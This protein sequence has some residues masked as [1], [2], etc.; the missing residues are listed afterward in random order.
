MVA[1]GKNQQERRASF[2]VH[3]PQ[4]GKVA[5]VVMEEEDDEQLSPATTAESKTQSKTTCGVHFNE[6]VAV[7]T[8]PS[9]NDF[10]QEELATLYLTKNEKR[11]NR[12]KFKSILQKLKLRSIS[13]STPST[14]AVANEE[15]LG[16]ENYLYPYEK[17]RLRKRATSLVLNYQGSDESLATTY[18]LITLPSTRKARERGLKLCQEQ[19]FRLDPSSS[20]LPNNDN[21]TTTIPSSLFVC[22]PPL[23]H[24]MAR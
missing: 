2:C 18:Q 7:Y 17:L 19:S 15:M 23:H 22:H 20:F 6:Q 8:I 12:K 13:S 9:L 16:L 11:E 24:I 3:Q 4:L 10:T 21:D 5:A 14:S 1:P